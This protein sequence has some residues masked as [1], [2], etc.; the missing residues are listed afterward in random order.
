MSYR[1]IVCNRSSLGDVDGDTLLAAITRSNFH[2]LCKQYDLKPDL[3]ETGKMSLE[4][5]A[6]SRDVAS[7]FMLY[8]HPDR[9]RPIVVNEWRLNKQPV[10]EALEDQLRQTASKDLR[11]RLLSTQYLVSIMLNKSQINDIGRLLA[12]E[13]ARWAA[14]RGNGIMRGLDGKWYRLNDHQ[15]F[16]LT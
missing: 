16:V 6:A 14:E 7:F 2:T 12:Y 4:V 3:I 8:Y 10:E 9:Q 5:V 13:L 1:I 11:E 15:A